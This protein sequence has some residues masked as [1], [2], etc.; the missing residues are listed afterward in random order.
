MATTPTH[1]RNEAYFLWKITCFLSV[2]SGKL[3][4]RRGF[5]TKSWIFALYI[6]AIGVL[7][8]SQ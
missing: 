5:L 6:F 7:Q 2:L 3:G 4:L 8:F 1:Y